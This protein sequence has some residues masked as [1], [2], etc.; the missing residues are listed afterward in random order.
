MA[1]LIKLEKPLRRGFGEAAMY[2]VQPLFVLINF[3]AILVAEVAKL[4]Q[5]GWPQIY[6]PATLIT[7]KPWFTVDHKNL[8]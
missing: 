2:L 4:L 1:K 5:G 3:L 8:Y 6:L 7:A